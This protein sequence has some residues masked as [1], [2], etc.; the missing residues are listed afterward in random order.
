MVAV[1]N[2]NGPRYRFGRARIPEALQQMQDV[3]DRLVDA[4]WADPAGD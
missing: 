2:L 3:V 4:F 1:L